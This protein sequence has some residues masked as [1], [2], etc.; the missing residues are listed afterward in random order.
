MAK[1][2]AFYKSD[3]N[4][5]WRNILMFSQYCNMHNSNTNQYNN[6]HTSYKVALIVWLNLLMNIHFGAL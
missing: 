5:A 4:D 3:H 2:V 1:N 6:G